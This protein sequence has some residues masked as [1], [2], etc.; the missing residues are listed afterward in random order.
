MN[1][2]NIILSEE[3]KAERQKEKE[4]NIELLVSYNNITQYYDKNHKNKTENLSLCPFFFGVIAFLFGLYSLPECKWF[5]LF[6]SGFLFNLSLVLGLYSF[7]GDLF[8]G[9]EERNLTDI[10]MIFAISSFGTLI[11]NVFLGAFHI[12]NT[13]N[14]PLYAM[15]SIMLMLNVLGYCFVAETEKE[16]QRIRDNDL[17][18]SMAE[19]IYSKCEIFYSLKSYSTFL[20]DNE[21]NIAWDFIKKAEDVKYKL[22]I[23]TLKF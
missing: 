1:N 15:F 2:T 8:S 10:A 9:D 20:I 5:F 4:K 13:E 17:R 19:E 12:P 18:H 23:G 3:K 6:I 16:C 22:K 14:F 7:K 11:S 21:L